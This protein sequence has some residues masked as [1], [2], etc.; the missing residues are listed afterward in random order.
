MDGSRKARGSGRSR[1]SVGETFKKYLDFNDLT[2]DMVY[3]VNRASSNPWS[4][5]HLV[6][7]DLIV[8]VAMKE[9]PS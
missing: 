5:V 2:I 9:L 1:E 4:R 7:E 3:D 8:V 6:G